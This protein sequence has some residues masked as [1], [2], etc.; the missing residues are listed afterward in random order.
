MTT[1]SWSDIDI[2]IENLAIQII[3]SGKKYN[4]IYGII[5]GG[6]VPAVM[7]SHKL[8]I[9]MSA[10]AP[11]GIILSSNALVVDEIYD[12]GKT[13]KEFLEFNDDVDIAVL[14]SKDKNAPVQFIGL[15]ASH[16]TTWIEFPW[17]KKND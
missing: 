14:L 2:V 11:T 4:H 12:S 5:R 16:N 3:Q 15:D 10:I 9:P 17:E 6:L 7:L 1:M 8:N 13:I